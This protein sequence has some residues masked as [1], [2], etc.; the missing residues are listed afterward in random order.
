LGHEVLK[1]QQ[2]P[3]VLLVKTDVLV[4]KANPVLKAHR[5]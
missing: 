1:V 2:A 5:D 4:L 3:K